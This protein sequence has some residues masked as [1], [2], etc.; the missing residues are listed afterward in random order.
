MVTVLIKIE[1]LF[2]MLSD[3]FADIKNNLDSIIHLVFS[4]RADNMSLSRIEI[5]YK[6][7]NK[8]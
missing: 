8:F 2:W 4:C 7:K 5:S 6:S 3:P 1:L